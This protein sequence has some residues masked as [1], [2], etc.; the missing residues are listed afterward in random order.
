MTCY[1]AVTAPMI[2]ASDI[3]RSRLQKLWTVYT[4]SVHAILIQHTVLLCSET[5]ITY[6]L[7]SAVVAH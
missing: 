2:A 5:S 4:S 7:Q 1:T 3:I 6:V